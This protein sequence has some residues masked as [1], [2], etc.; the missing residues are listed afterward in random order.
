MAQRDKTSV[1]SSS[2]T[3]FDKIANHYEL[4]NFLA[5]FGIESLWR[6]KALTYI[7]GE[8]KLLLD[9]GVGTGAFSERI[10]DKGFI[11]GLDPSI[12]MMDIGKKKRPYIKFVNGFGESL[13]FKSEIFDYVISAY[14]MRN[15]KNIEKCL[16]EIKRV[17]KPSGILLLLEFFPPER[18]FYKLFFKIY[19]GKI[20]PFF[21]K[22]LKGTSLPVNYFYNSI[23]N[24]MSKDDFVN[25]LKKRGFVKIK[26][27]QLVFGISFYIRGVKSGEN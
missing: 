1:T 20:I 21:Y 8:N 2:S 22:F 11:V 10:K 13:P 15:V 3:I 9:F 18:T 27:S 14:V 25:L 17:L 24:F 19:L 26:K 12:K 23:Y 6:R 4:F 16:D 7:K 5:S